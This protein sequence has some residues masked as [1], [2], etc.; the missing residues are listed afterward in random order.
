MPVVWQSHFAESEIRREY[1]YPGLGAWYEVTPNCVQDSGLASRTATGVSTAY[2]HSGTR[3]MRMT[4]DTTMGVAGCR[5]FLNRY[6]QEWPDAYPDGLYMAA[7]LLIPRFVRVNG[8]WQVWQ[9]KVRAPSGAS[10]AVSHSLQIVNPRPNALCFQWTYK[11]GED[12]GIRGPYAHDDASVKRLLAT[13][14]LPIG[15][16]FHVESY[17]RPSADYTGRSTVWQDGMQLFDLD[18]I[19]T[20]PPDHRQSWSVNHYG[21]QL[22]P[23]RSH[24]YV[25]DVVHSTERIGPT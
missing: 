1:R 25:D 12:L 4:I 10:V 14:D 20:L 3:S 21:E 24:L 2:A 5:T 9:Y 18:Q 6:L 23:A 7:W 13:A 16:W 17:I 22:S 8:W 15:R 19:V 11:L